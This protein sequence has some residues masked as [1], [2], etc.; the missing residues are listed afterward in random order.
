MVANG[1]HLELRLGD[2][3]VHAEFLVDDYMTVNLLI[4]SMSDRFNALMADSFKSY[5]SNRIHSPIAFTHEL[6]DKVRGRLEQILQLYPELSLKDLYLLSGIGKTIAQILVS[7]QGKVQD[8]V[9]R[10]LA[11]I[12]ALRQ[13]L[14]EEAVVPSPISEPKLPETLGEETVLEIAGLQEIDQTKEAERLAAA[15][16]AKLEAQR[17]AKKKRAREKRDLARS[18]QEDDFNI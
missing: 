11:N 3:L 9:I 7:N 18:M 12:S 15:Q 2:K 8:E 10:L 6:Y 4:G 1:S 16:Q 5:P 14:S 17:Q 13:R